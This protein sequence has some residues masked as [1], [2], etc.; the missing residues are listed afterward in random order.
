MAN[1]VAESSPP[2][3]RTTARCGT[4]ILLPPFAFHQARE[5]PLR[6]FRRFT[7]RIARD[8][9]IHGLACRSGVAHL[10]LAAGYV[11]QRVRHLRALGIRPDQFLLV[12]DR[13]AVVAQVVVR[14][15][16]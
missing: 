9:A 13:A 5:P 4:G 12:R 14:I 15:A 2:E 16:D 10:D 8:E 1:V 3:R 6:L 7:R 11:E